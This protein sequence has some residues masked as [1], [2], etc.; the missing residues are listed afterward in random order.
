MVKFNSI[1][2]GGNT[3]AL[4]LYEEIISQKRSYGYHF[5]GFLRSNKEKRLL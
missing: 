2:I 1:I 3:E 4:A 5:I